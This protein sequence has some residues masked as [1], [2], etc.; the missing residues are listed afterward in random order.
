[1]TQ[2]EENDPRS[3]DGQEL[4]LEEWYRNTCTKWSYR[5]KKMDSEEREEERQKV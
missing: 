1:M 2:K 5:P 4:K 3:L